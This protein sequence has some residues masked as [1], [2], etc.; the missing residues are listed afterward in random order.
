[1]VAWTCLFALHNNGTELF[2]TV[3][4]FRSFQSPTPIHT[5]TQEYNLCVASVTVTFPDQFSLNKVTDV[6]MIAELSVFTQSNHFS[7]QIQ[8]EIEI[9]GGH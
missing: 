7:F 8:Q 4:S 5:T 1:M 3:L 6:R 9:E 2:V